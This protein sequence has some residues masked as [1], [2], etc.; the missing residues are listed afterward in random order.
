MT[1]A[2]LDG[3][4]VTAKPARHGNVERRIDSD[5]CRFVLQ[6]VKMYGIRQRIAARAS[7]RDDIDLF[8]AHNEI[9][10]V[11]ARVEPRRIAD[12]VFHL[13]LQGE[14]TFSNGKIFRACGTGNSGKHIGLFVAHLVRAD[15][16]ELVCHPIF[17]RTLRNRIGVVAA[18]LPYG[19]RVRCGCRRRAADLCGRC[20]VDRGKRPRHM[21]GGKHR[22]IVKKSSGVVR[23]EVLRRPRLLG[24]GIAV[25]VDIE[26]CTVGD[27]ETLRIILS[28]ELTDVAAVLHLRDGGRGIGGSGEHVR[29]GRLVDMT[30][31]LPRHIICEDVRRAVRQNL[32]VADILTRCT[33]QIFS[34][35]ML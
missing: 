11:V 15:I 21:V 2:L 10:S 31:C 6:R 20:E 13:Q 16:H 3:D 17:S 26:I 34:E 19:I 27:P 7:T 30:C 29:Y 22:H 25:G 28:V 1:V 4:T 24:R 18:R 32:D 5:L 12:A 35:D 9:F 8:S 14:C 23:G 33:K